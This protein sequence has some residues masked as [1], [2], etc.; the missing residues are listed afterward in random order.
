MQIFFRK[1][2]EDAQMV[3]YS[4]GDDFE[5]FIRTL[6]VAKQTSRYTPDDGREDRVFRKAS[7]GIAGR[8]KQT[9]EWPE[10][11]SHTSG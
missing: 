2:Q 1:D 7:W 8:F 3:R 5:H 11:G 9:G 4:F 10:R 6:T